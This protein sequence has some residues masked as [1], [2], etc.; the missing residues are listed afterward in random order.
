MQLVLTDGWLLNQAN[1]CPSLTIL[2]D[3]LHTVWTGPAGRE[4][5]ITA[6]QLGV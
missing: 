1:D 2:K 4:R 3:K 5:Y 6:R